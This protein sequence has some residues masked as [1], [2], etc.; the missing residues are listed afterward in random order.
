MCIEARVV[1]RM[2]NQAQAGAFERWRT[3]VSELASQRK[4]MARIVQ[5]MQKRGVVLALDSWH[6][7]VNSACKSGRKRSGAMLSCRGLSSGCCMPQL[8]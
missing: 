3:N 4:L 2:L 6:S 5:R 8:P 7:N 1:R